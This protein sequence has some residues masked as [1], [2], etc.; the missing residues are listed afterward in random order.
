MPKFDFKEYAQSG[1]LDTQARQA[2]TQAISQAERAGLPRAYSLNPQQK[3]P[4]TE[5]K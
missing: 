3:T 5:K 4:G 1:Q 2:I